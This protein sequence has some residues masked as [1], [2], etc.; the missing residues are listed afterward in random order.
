LR[1]L[2]KP[3]LISVALLGGRSPIFRL[4]YPIDQKHKSRII[5]VLDLLTSYGGGTMSDWLK[6]HNMLQRAGLSVL[7]IVFGI[8]WVVG[9]VQA[10][11]EIKVDKLMQSMA[12][13]ERLYELNRG[14]QFWEYV[15]ENGLEEYVDKVYRGM[16]LIGVTPEG[17]PIFYKLDNAAAARTSRADQLYP[18]AGNGYSITGAFTTY[19][20]MWDGGVA[21]TTHDCFNTF[22]GI[23]RATNQDAG[24]AHFHAQHVAGTM[25]AGGSA[26]L[27]TAQYR[28]MSYEAY[29]HV[30]DWFSD[31][32]EMINAVTNGNTRITNHS[33]GQP[34]GWEYEGGPV[35]WTW[36]GNV[37]LEYDAEFGRYNSQI[38]R[39]W[40]DIAHDNPYLT[41][42]VSAG[43][44][45]SDSGAGGGQHYHGN[46]GTTYT[47]YHEPDGGNLGY[48]IIGY[49]GVCKN[50]FT[51][52]AC[53]D[54]QQYTGPGSVSITGFSSFGPTDDG[55][56]KPDIVANGANLMSAGVNHDSH[57][58]GMS[59]TSMS[60]P[61]AAGTLNLLFL[62]FLDLFE[63]EP[64]STTLRGLVIHTADECGS[65]D[66]PDYRFGWGLLN[67]LAAAQ[68]M[69]WSVENPVALQEGELADG[70][71][72]VQ[73][74]IPLE[75]ES[76]RVTLMWNEP[77]GQT[78]FGN[79]DPTP[80]LVNDL[81][82]RL[83]ETGTNTTYMPYILGGLSNPTL[84][85]APGDNIV[86][87]VEQIYLEDVPAG[88]YE[89]RVTHKDNLTETTS[90]SLLI[91]G[92]IDADDPR[93]P[94]ANL[95]ADVDYVNGTA[96]LGWDHPGGGSFIEYLIIRNDVQIGTTAQTSF[97]DDFPEFGEY[98][99]E[100]VASYDEGESLFN[101]TV[102][103]MYFGP[104]AASFFSYRI[105]D[106]PAL[107]IKLMWEQSREEEVAYDDGEP[108]NSYLT[109]SGLVEPGA[110]AAQLFTLED[111]SSLHSI[112][113]N[114][115]DAV[116]GGDFRFV[117]L[118]YAD[119][120]VIPG[121]LIWNSETMQVDEEGWF[122]Y[123]LPERHIF[124][125]GES[126][127]IG[128]EWLETGATAINVDTSDDIQNNRSSVY[129]DIGQG[130]SWIPLHEFG[131]PGA[132]A[133][134]L[135][136]R[137]IFGADEPI[138]QAGLIEFNVHR[139]GGVIATTTDLNLLETIPGAGS[140]EYT[141]ESI[142]AQG[143]AWSEVL[144]IDSGSL[145]VEEPTQADLPME[146]SIGD[147]YPNP[148][149]PSVAVPV[150]LA[151][152]ADVKLRVFDI[153]GRQVA[154]VSN[155][156]MTAGTHTLSWTAEG[157]SSGV[158]F[159]RVTAGPMS[160]TQKVVL[161]R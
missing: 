8:A 142:Y 131:F 140:Y 98:I 103:V 11:P 153:L 71:S 6:S 32:S 21:R 118:E 58:T 9:P 59:G 56:I 73:E 30:Y 26:D 94:V 134:D 14:P 159:L 117:V 128:L 139:D 138:G 96:D 160:S 28:G 23:P 50:V 24:A 5:P 126:V 144:T 38:S 37:N 136:L 31:T 2:G 36:W 19:M 49:R 86:D 137:G 135:M 143:S 112:R 105:I 149:N 29:L 84:P 22:F 7:I 13:A 85:A 154:S 102:E 15:E 12:E 39:P 34:M 146:F 87:N 145:G 72:I 155:G 4:S 60:S 57:Y 141:L 75:G 40:D 120:P 150:T 124:A 109:F 130:G 76:I 92:A 61:S 20:A 78:G 46:G 116:D 79:N 161:M 10:R 83:V 113:A 121:D 93:E 133:G 151:S 157:V 42:C 62:H 158:Y 16:S 77:Q 41:I 1:I 67:A 81:D 100:V 53:N 95:E 69:D 47:D 52:G 114:I 104:S 119:D 35:P 147:A 148:F 111:N 101:P 125:S 68:F 152:A 27:G 80:I 127:W 48:D 90:Y 66:G 107:E 99:Y 97:T 115:S 156:Q 123:D 89:V 65:W 106:E 122:D 82:V 74:I 43:N 51:I 108:D 17:D 132:Y 110:I 55:R 44:D 63:M 64:L 45:R 3:E 129:A 25:I 88:T 54:V 18:D 33:Y 91:S 70:E